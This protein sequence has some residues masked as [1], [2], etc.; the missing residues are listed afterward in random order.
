[1]RPTEIAAFALASAH[2]RSGDRESWAK[3]INPPGGSSALVV[4]LVVALVAAVA[5]A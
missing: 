5:A 1:M 2:H 3:V 4:A